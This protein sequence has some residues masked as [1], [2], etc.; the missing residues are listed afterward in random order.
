MLCLVAPMGL[1]I[2]EFVFFRELY[3][4]MITIILTSLGWYFRKAIMKLGKNYSLH[5][6]HFLLVYGLSLPIASRAGLGVQFQLGNH[7]LWVH[8]HIQF[9]LLVDYRSRTC[10]DI[11]TGSGLKDAVHSVTV[12]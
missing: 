3:C 2:A 6:R 11:S 9:E 1:S 8:G 12:Q 5:S 4:A 10:L 7:C